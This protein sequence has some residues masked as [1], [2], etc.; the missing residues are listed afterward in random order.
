M[1]KRTGIKA[2]EEQ[3]HFLFDS[4]TVVSRAEKMHGQCRRWTILLP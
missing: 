2:L 4:E 1:P 3:E